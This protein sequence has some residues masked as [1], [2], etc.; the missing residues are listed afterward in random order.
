MGKKS[1]QNS[2]PVYKGHL[3]V[4]SSVSFIN[5][6]DCIFNNLIIYIETQRLQGLSICHLA[7]QMILMTKKNQALL[8]LNNIHTL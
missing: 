4:F 5:R 1:T 7:I 2:K 3:H 8:F 6:F